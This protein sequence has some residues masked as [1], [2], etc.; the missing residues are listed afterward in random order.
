MTKPKES[1]KN[2]GAHSKL[3]KPPP[4]CS[5][6]NL[7]LATDEPKTVRK[8]I[9]YIVEDAKYP[10]GQ[11]ERVVTQ[12]LRAFALSKIKHSAKKRPWPKGEIKRNQESDF[13]VNTKLDR[14]VRKTETLNRKATRESSFELVE[15]EEEM[16]KPK[17]VAKIA[18]VPH[19]PLHRLGHYGRSTLS[20]NRTLEPPLTDAPTKAAQEQFS[21]ETDDG[22]KSTSKQRAKISKSLTQTSELSKKV[23]YTSPSSTSIPETS[24]QICSPENKLPLPPF[25]TQSVISHHFKR[26]SQ[27]PFF[28]PRPAFSTS[29]PMARRVGS[30]S[31]L[32]CKR[33]PSKISMVTR[34]P[35]PVYIDVPLS[36]DDGHISGVSIFTRDVVQTSLEK[37]SSSGCHKNQLLATPP[38]PKF[39]IS[40]DLFSSQQSPTKRG[41]LFI[42]NSSFDSYEEY[43]NTLFE[44]VLKTWGLPLDVIHPKG[45]ELYKK[46]DII[47]AV[48]GKETV[49]NN[50]VPPVQKRRTQRT[51]AFAKPVKANPSL[52]KFISMDERRLRKPVGRVKDIVEI[53]EDRSVDRTMT[54][55]RE[56]GRILQRPSSVSSDN[57]AA[58]SRQIMEGARK[59]VR[60]GV[61]GG[62]WI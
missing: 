8:G 55:I 19:A 30:A 16:E 20:V 5:S 14:A 44:D 23:I 32:F 15:K 62:R 35:V 53:F 43:Q 9:D 59:K 2:K 1:E 18:E 33:S 17:L 25:P 6:S 51:V 45:V 27:S 48:P 61:I 36:L 47:A 50:N 12:I 58:E 11:K 13:K 37:M 21:K 52:K 40:A 22:Q 26:P 42:A 24:N 54:P 38:T 60:E 29:T 7:D 57:L 34:K 4:S 41:S 39:N 56:L 31:N 46:T 3:T 28:G 10:K 49:D